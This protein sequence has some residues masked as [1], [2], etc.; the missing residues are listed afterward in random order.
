[1]D[2]TWAIETADESLPVGVRLRPLVGR[3]DRRGVFTEAFRA[4]WPTGVRPVQWNVVDSDAGVLRGVHVH[5]RHDDYLIVIAGRATIGLRDLRRGSATVGRVA[6]VQLDGSH[7]RAIT[8]PHGVA[9]GFYF[10]ERSTHLYAVSRYFDPTDELACH[11]ADDELGLDWPFRG[12]PVLSERDAA[13]GTLAALLAAIEP[14]QP[15]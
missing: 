8:I 10:H 13:A 1:M 3:S 7:R 6:L 14:F 4:T 9:H 5:V 12:E 15:L 2:A 11:W